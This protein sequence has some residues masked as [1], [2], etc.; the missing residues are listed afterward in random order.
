[1]NH[2]SVDK[3]NVRDVHLSVFLK[4]PNSNNEK[5]YMYGTVKKYQHNIYNKK[6][7]IV[8][9]LNTQEQLLLRTTV[10]RR[11]NSESSYDT[12]VVLL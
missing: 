4:N 6:I 12:Q 1:M 10:W 7:Q 8:D 11:G 9:A 3:E 5:N 2:I